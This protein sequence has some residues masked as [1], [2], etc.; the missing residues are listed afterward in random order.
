MRAD[1]GFEELRSVDAKAPVA[2]FRSDRRRCGS[3]L[4]SALRPDSNQARQQLAPGPL[5]Y[6]PLEP[7]R[8]AVLYPCRVAL[9]QAGTMDKPQ[10]P[11]RALAA[12]SSTVAC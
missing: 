2:A 7:R 8:G 12:P 1:D 3:G 6:S 9:L 5:F 11:L 10:S 4:G